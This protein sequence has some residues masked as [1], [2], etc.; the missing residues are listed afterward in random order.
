[1]LYFPSI[2]IDSLEVYTQMLQIF[3]LLFATPATTYTHSV[4]SPAGSTMF[5]STIHS[6]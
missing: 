2:R 6:L 1:M 3:S 5:K 4:A